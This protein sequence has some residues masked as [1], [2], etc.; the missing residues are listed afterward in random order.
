MLNVKLVAYGTPDY[1]RTLAL[2]DKVLRAPLGLAF[3]EAFLAQEKDPGQFHVAAFEGDALL[4]CLI[5]T[6]AGQGFLKMRQVA[7][8]DNVQ[9]KGVGR[10]LC[11]FSESFG[12]ERGFKEIILNARETAVPFY[13]RLSYETVSDLFVEVGIP[14]R[15]M[16]KRL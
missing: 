15:K 13:S 2:R 1:R 14:H 9:G 16:R 12:R 11:D 8:D 7:V 10:A 6:D 3:D 5:L 4:G